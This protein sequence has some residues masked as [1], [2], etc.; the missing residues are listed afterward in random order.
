MLHHRS[1]VGQRERSALRA[2]RLLRRRLEAAVTSP[3]YP[4]DDD[5]IVATHGGDPPQGPRIE[6]RAGVRYLVVGC[7][8]YALSD[9]DVERLRRDLR[10]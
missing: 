1:Y 5:G 2:L 4:Q 9:G 8:R 6:V 7:D 3:Y 10:D